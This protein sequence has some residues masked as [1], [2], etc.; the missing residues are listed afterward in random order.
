MLDW[1]KYIKDWLNWFIIFS[2]VAIVALLCWYFS[3]QGPFINKE[4]YWGDFGSILSAVTGLIAFVG[5]LFTLRQSKQ[6]FINNENRS[7]FF[8]LLNIF[9]SCRDSLQVQKVEWKYNE[10]TNRWDVSQL[11]ELCL[12]EQSYQQIYTELCRLFYYEIKKD[13]PK[14]F[15]QNDFLK[16][17][18]DSKIMMDNQLVVAVNNIYKEYHWVEHKGFCEIKPVDPSIYDNICFNAINIYWEENNF[19]PIAEACMRTAN[20]C[21]SKYNN[22]L[23]TYFRNTY[24]ILDM[25]S[26]FD[27]PKKYSNIFRAQLSK[28][29]LAIL[30]FNSFSQFSTPRTRQLYLNADLF[31]NLECKDILLTVCQDNES[32]S[33]EIYIN[34]LYLFSQRNKDKEY[35]SKGV[36]KKLYDSISEK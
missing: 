22:E 27:S 18:V 28:F 10:K 33:R 3:T 25:V 16:R 9:I 11:N 1:K 34:F 29:E 26:E 6:Q 32:V 8:D 30:F 36:L 35:F 14:Y 20:I 4:V 24:Y 5:L 21:F 15:H 31:N 23:G 17:V 2:I 12:P 13:I 19:K 7:I